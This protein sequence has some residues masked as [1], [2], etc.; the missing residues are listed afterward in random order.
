MTESYLHEL[1]LSTFDGVTGARESLQDLTD[2][3]ALSEI[4]HQMCD[5]FLS[6]LVLLEEYDSAERRVT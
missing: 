2:G 1:Q 3:V 4:M 6:I 5:C